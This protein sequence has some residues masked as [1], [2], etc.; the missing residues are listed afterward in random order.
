MCFSEIW[1]WHSGFETLRQSAVLHLQVWHDQAV[2]S[3][4]ASGLC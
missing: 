4:I 2:V 1:H 3:S